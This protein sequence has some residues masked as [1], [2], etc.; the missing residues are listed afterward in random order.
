MSLAATLAGCPRP[1]VCTGSRASRA[2]ISRRW[3]GSRVAALAALA[4]QLGMRSVVLAS[5]TVG[6]LTQTLTLLTVALFVAPGAAVAGWPGYPLPR[7]HFR[8]R[9][10]WLSEL[11]TRRADIDA[12]VRRRSAVDPRT[13]M[14]DRA[15]RICA[16]GV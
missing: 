2:G 12:D 1:G 14:Q 11:T 15:T 8:W 7:W 13:G 4:P 10:H 9:R 16:Y 5:V 6:P 3:R